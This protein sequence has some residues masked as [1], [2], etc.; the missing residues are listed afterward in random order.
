VDNGS[1]NARG[2]GGVSGIGSGAGGPSSTGGSG[3]G[4]YVGGGGANATSAVDPAGPL[5]KMIRRRFKTSLVSVPFAIG[6][7]TNFANVPGTLRAVGDVAL[8][9]LLFC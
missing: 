1:S 5:L 7:C 6:L 9:P 2:A 8:I 3:G 4:G